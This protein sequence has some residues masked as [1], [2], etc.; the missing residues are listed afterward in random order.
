MRSLIAISMLISL[1]VSQSLILEA[2]DGTCGYLNGERLASYGCHATTQK[3]AIYYPASTL[4]VDAV[5]DISVG[6]TDFATPS[7]KTLTPRAAKINTVVITP[8][9]QV[10]YPAV[11]CCDPSAGDCTAQPTT[12][13]DAF[14]HPYSTLCAGNCP[15]DPMTLKCTAGHALHCNQIQIQSP[16]YYQRNADSGDGEAHKVGMGAA[17]GPAPGWFCGASALPTRFIESTIISSRPVFAEESL[18]PEASAVFVSSPSDDNQVNEPNK[19]PST[20][21]APQATSPFT[22]VP[23]TI[24]LGE[25][26]GTSTPLPGPNPG[27]LDDGFVPKDGHIH[28]PD[29]GSEDCCVDEP[30]FDECC[31]DGVVRRERRLQRRRD[32]K[33]HRIGTTV[34]TSTVTSPNQIGLA[35]TTVT[36]AAAPAMVIT[37]GFA[38]VSTMYVGQSDR[39]PF[40]EAIRS[41]NILAPAPT[42]N[43]TTTSLNDI[44]PHGREGPTKGPEDQHGHIHVRRIIAGAIGGLLGLVLLAVLVRWCDKRRKLG[45]NHG[46][47][48][49]PNKDKD[50]DEDNNDQPPARRS[51][52]AMNYLQDKYARLKYCLSWTEDQSGE[53]TPPTLH[54]RNPGPDSN[55]DRYTASPR[56]G[57]HPHGSTPQEQDVSSL[58]SG[59]ADCQRGGTDGSCPCRSHVLTTNWLAQVQDDGGPPY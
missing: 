49:Q 50:E 1:A 36:P 19:G 26:I 13:V 52:R 48:R 33:F 46:G 32:T 35:T 20:Q 25:Q 27:T 31:A 3:C 34:V 53:S 47:N 56:G 38:V 21:V 57:I 4:A 55:P 42:L 24:T 39:P 30:A 8:A 16:L 51:A 9:P 23:F 17:K 58:Y 6:L 28:E 29:A 12:C 22:T 59:F 11:V 10:D 2:P 40:T 18:L 43:A 7:F 5:T 54:P 15:D 14:E 44:S 45:E 37:E 41:W